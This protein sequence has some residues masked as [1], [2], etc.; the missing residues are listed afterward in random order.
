MAVNRVWKEYKELTREL[1]KNGPDKEISLAPVDD[2]DILHWTV[3]ERS[4]KVH[5]G[6]NLQLLA[7]KPQLLCASSRIWQFFDC[8]SHAIAT[9]FGNKHQFVLGYLQGNPRDALA[10]MFSGDSPS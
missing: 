3:R 7:N 1:S 6:R 10:K 2:S 9:K 4:L 8:L 5:L